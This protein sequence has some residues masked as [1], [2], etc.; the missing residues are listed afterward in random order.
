[1]GWFG[2]GFFFLL[3]V[4]E[5]FVQSPYTVTLLKVTVW[6]L[7]QKKNLSAPSVLIKT[8]GTFSNK[9][10]LATFSTLTTEF[11]LGERAALL[12][13]RTVCH[14]GSAEAWQ[15]LWFRDV[16]SKVASD[17]CSD[18]AKRRDFLC[19]SKPFI[20]VFFWGSGQQRYWK[21]QNCSV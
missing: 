15:S 5:V 7:S 13:P 12:P 17:H 4:V 10:H 20:F 2:F 6:S 11:L 3:L 8:A 16:K 19:P 21:C 14:R 18:W 9:T 1:M